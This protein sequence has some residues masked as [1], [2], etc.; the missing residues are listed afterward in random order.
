M[1][2]FRE[3]GAEKIAICAAEALLKGS[4][5]HTDHQPALLR[6]L[7]PGRPEPGGETMR[8]DAPFG[9][10]ENLVPKSH[11]ENQPLLQF[12]P[13]WKCCENPPTTRGSKWNGYQPF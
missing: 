10:L 7:L 6:A 2:N 9:V 5:G 3:H 11:R 1:T 4:R 12:P 13:M 8:I